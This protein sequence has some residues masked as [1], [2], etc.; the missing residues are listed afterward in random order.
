MQLP[1]YLVVL[2][3][4]LLVTSVFF[5]HFV[6]HGNF[7]GIGVVKQQR[8]RRHPKRGRIF[9]H[10]SSS[11]RF[12]YDWRRRLSW[13][14][15]RTNSHPFLMFY[16]ANS[17][18]YALGLLGALMLAIAYCSVAIFTLSNAYFSIAY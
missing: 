18:M 2:S 7:T 14:L 4:T 5:I 10:F 11:R 13:F 6:S 17:R 1:T 15:S 9:S 8:Q 12:F 3:Y 16:C